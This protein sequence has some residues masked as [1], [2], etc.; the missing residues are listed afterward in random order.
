MYWSTTKNAMVV[1]S[2]IKVAP[3]LPVLFQEKQFQTWSSWHEWWQKR[4]GACGETQLSV[5]NRR[6]QQRAI[7]WGLH[8]RQPTVMAWQA[9]CYAQHQTLQTLPE[10]VFGD[11]YDTPYWL[12]SMLAWRVP[13]VLWWQLHPTS[14]T[15]QRVAAWQQYAVP[16]FRWFQNVH[17]VDRKMRQTISEQQCATFFC[18]EHEQSLLK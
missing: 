15:R 11:E 18:A 2:G 6:R 8:Y 10:W 17:L 9:L 7:S 13:L 5:A 12:N 16:S 1:L 4:E 14:S 3:F